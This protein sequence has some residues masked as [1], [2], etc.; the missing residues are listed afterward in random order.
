MLSVQKPIQVAVLILAGT[1]ALAAEASESRN[2]FSKRIEAYVA[3]R[4]HVEQRA[5]GP[6]PSFS[7]AEIHRAAEAQAEAIRAARPHAKQGNIFTA[8]I[9]SRLRRQIRAVM[10][11]EGLRADRLSEP[12]GDAPDR[13]ISLAVNGRFDWSADAVMPGVLIAALPPLPADLQYRFVRRDLVLVDI[14]A[15]LIVDILPKALD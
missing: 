13:P 5:P 15:G 1:T 10:V 14:V 7:M 9:A 12:V 3:L 4:R 11:V 6:R 2:Q 8:R